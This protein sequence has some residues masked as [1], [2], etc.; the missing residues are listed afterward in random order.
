M[1]ALISTIAQAYFDT[2]DW[3]NGPLCQYIDRYGWMLVIGSII[4]ALYHN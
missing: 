3:I 2:V 4:Y 1:I